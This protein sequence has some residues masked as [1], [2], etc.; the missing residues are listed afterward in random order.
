M[1]KA[2]IINALS[3]MRTVM[4][5]AGLAHE[6]ASVMIDELERYSIYLNSRLKRF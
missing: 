2:D 4:Q 3:V 5:K 6:P 1:K